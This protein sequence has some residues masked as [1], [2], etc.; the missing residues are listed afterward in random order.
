METVCGDVDQLGLDS[1]FVTVMMNLEL[2][3]NNGIS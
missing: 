1:K 2:P 3:I